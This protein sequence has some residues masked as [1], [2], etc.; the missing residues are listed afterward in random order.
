MVD[1]E[2]SKQNCHLRLSC[3]C[4]EEMANKVEITETWEKIV[5]SLHGSKERKFD[6]T[7]CMY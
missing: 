2:G 1:D 7:E 6:A 3:D 5:I 4:Q